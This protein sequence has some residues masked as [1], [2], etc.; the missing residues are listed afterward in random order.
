M[1]E[2]KKQNAAEIQKNI[3]QGMITQIYA[4]MKILHYLSKRDRLKVQSE[5]CP[6]TESNLISP[7]LKMYCTAGNYDYL[8]CFKGT[9]GKSYLRN[10]YPLTLEHK[11]KS[12]Q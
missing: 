11:F 2:I 8:F 12:L 10:S 7:G 4:A 3:K 5:L 9:V 6:V 1:E